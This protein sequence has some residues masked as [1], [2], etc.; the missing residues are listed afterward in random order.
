MPR[1]G[2]G[3][4]AQ[5]IADMRQNGVTAQEHRRIGRIQD[6]RTKSRH[7]AEVAAAAQKKAQEVF[8]LQPPNFNPRRRAERD[9]NIAYD[10]YYDE[11]A[12]AER[13]ARD[14]YEEQ[15]RGAQ[16]IYARLTNDLGGLGNL[17]PEYHGISNQLAQALGAQGLGGQTQMYSPTDAADMG[18]TGQAGMA[19][20]AQNQ[21][22]WNQVGRGAQAELA[23]SAA[24][25]LGYV[26]S[27]GARASVD[28]ADVERNYLESL[29]DQLRELNESELGL[30]KDQSRDVLARI[31][32]LRDSQFGQ[33]LQ[34]GQ[35][36]LNQQAQRQQ[37]KIAKFIQ[38]FIAK[39]IGK[40]GNRGNNNRGGNRHGKNNGVSDTGRSPK[41]D[42]YDGT[43]KENPKPT[44]VVPGPTGNNPDTYDNNE[45]LHNDVR[46]RARNV[47]GTDD[48]TFVNQNGMWIVNSGP[49]AGAKVTDQKLLKALWAR[50]KSNRHGKGN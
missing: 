4:R 35:Y 27:L 10:P 26:G 2:Q 25:H 24:D 31:D 29:H 18:A 30:R 44:K 38:D 3:Q 34:Y 47:Y 46:Q 45:Q 13:E 37:Q 42:E 48:V 16:D 6:A 32:E 7:G 12:K 20:N 43:G 23:G 1:R 19:V 39:E 36:Q 11:I 8:Q 22:V 14:L 15:A 33:G 41:T 49:Q 5:R 50:R 9:I 40:G 21:N 28:R 17:A